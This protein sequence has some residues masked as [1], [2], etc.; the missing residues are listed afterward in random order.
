MQPKPLFAGDAP[1]S[2]SAFDLLVSLGALGLAV[3]VLRFQLWRALAFVFPRKLEVEPDAPADQMAP[4][5]SLQPR[6]D[7]LVR[8]GF[9][10]LGRHTERRPLGPLALTYDFAAPG[11]QT[12]AMLVC[13][14]GGESGLTFL[15]PLA[16]N[17]FVVTS[18]YRRPA[19]SIP[20]RYEAGGVDGG[21]PARVYRAHRKRMERMVGTQQFEA[22]LEGCVAAVVRCNALWGS[23]EVRQRHLF[24]LLWTLGSLG[25]VVVVW[26]DRFGR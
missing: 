26:M 13:S 2:P 4:P 21:E 22:A 11:E 7:A 12:Y 6:I 20:G 14:P 3:G 16:E 9:V 1:V 17:G 10:P 24:A 8:C 18:D 5:Q 19:R 15:S 23:A 25:M